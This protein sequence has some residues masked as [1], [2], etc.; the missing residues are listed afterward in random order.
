MESIAFPLNNTIIQGVDWPIILTFYEEDDIT[1]VNLA[2][3]KISYTV[4][5]AYDEDDLDAAAYVK[6]NTSDF[7]IDADPDG[8]GAVTNRISAVVPRSTVHAIPVG[9]HVQDLDIVPQTTSRLG[10][11]GSGQLVVKAQVGR[12]EPT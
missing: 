6:L 4:K 9:T 3:A 11:Y 8:G 10:T 2:G 1:P 5:P 12:R 7:T